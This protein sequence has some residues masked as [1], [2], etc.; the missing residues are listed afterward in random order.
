MTTRFSN[1]TLGYI[2]KEKESAFFRDTC[3]VTFIETLFTILQIRDNQHVHSPT[4]RDYGTHTTEHRSAIKRLTPSCLCQLRDHYIQPSTED[5]QHVCHSDAGAENTGLI[6]I[7]NRMMVTKKQE[8]EGGW[9]VTM[10]VKFQ[11]EKKIVAVCF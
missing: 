4:N 7:G 6:D 5:K 10:G 3:A 9:R 2:Y 1:L 8:Q 11:L